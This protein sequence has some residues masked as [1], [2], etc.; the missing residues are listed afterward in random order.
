MPECTGLCLFKL[1]VDFRSRWVVYGYSVG[2]YPINLNNPC[3]SLTLTL[4]CKNRDKQLKNRCMSF[5]CKM[6]IIDSD[7]KMPFLV[8][9]TPNTALTANVIAG[10]IDRVGREM[11]EIDHNYAARFAMYARKW[12]REKIPQ[13]HS[14]QVKSFYPWLAGAGYGE[15]RTNYFVRLRR[16]LSRLGTGAGEST[17][18]IKYE[19]YDK[20]KPPRI[21]SSPSDESKTILGGLVKAF[22]EN[23]FNLPYFIKGTDPKDWPLKLEAI[24]K[25]SPVME[26]DYS[27]FE[28]HHHEVYAMITHYAMQHA[29]REL[30]LTNNEARLIAQLMVGYN[31]I[32]FNNV[33]ACVDERLMSGALWTSSMNGL[34]NLLVSSFVVLQSK[35]VNIEGEDLYD[36]FDDEFVGIFEGDDGMTVAT[37]INEKVVEMLGLDLKFK[38]YDRYN[39]AKFCGVICDRDDKKIVMDPVRV[40]RNFFILDSKYINFRDTKQL[41]LLRAK[42][43]SY[44]YNLNDCP[45]IGPLCQAVCDKTAS[46]DMSCIMSETDMRQRIFAEKAIAC[47]Q[48]RNAPSVSQTSR[49]I[50]EQR[51]GIPVGLQLLIEDD[52]RNWKG[53][54]LT[55]RLME[56]SVNKSADLE[57]ALKFC[58]ADESRAPDHCPPTGLVGVVAERGLKGDVYRSVGSKRKIVRK[59][60]L[61]RETVP[62]VVL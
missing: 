21:I 19:H 36:K 53:W 43:L 52:I 5:Y 24:F 41:G 8:P 58:V 54:V 16:E 25:D 7:L 20:P 33:T 40:M 11:P 38:F 56:L 48:W 51:F 1:A 45:I 60:T 15:A 31:K 9:Y 32:K 28:A 61:E 18:F 14:H 57:H 12:I 55:T 42:A 49:L 35:H 62:D 3:R 29:I 13:I 44:K 59:S 30:G 26:T 22:D 27:R 39:E 4:K 46:V 23:L 50:V 17:G 2:D 37:E 34:L 47:K 6:H 10:C